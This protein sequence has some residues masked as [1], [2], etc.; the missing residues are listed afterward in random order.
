MFGEAR[1]RPDSPRLHLHDIEDAPDCGMM[2]TIAE[3]DETHP[4][5]RRSV[6]FDAYDGAAKPAAAATA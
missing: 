2:L 5:V 1:P 6:S 4:R 3:V